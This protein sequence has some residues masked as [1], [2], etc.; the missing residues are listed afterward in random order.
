M[1]KGNDESRNGARIVDMNAY[2]MRNHPASGGLQKGASRLK[3]ALMGSP[4]NPDLDDPN[5]PE[6]TGQEARIS[7][8]SPRNIY[9]AM[10]GE[11]G[12]KPPK[13]PKTKTGDAGKDKP[14]KSGNDD[15]NPYGMPRP[16]LPE[17]ESREDKYKNG[18]YN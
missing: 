8:L 6:Y 14:K 5:T 13:K 18:W 2:K 17:R 16:K 3:N 11:G 1:A 4:G 9:K 15:A 7:D 10:A 12:K